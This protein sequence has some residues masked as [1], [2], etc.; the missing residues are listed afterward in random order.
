MTTFRSC[1]LWCDVC[2]AEFRAPSGMVYVTDAR[3]VAAQQGW[4][5]GTQD[6]RASPTSGVVFQRESD[7]CPA[8]AGK[9]V[10]A[11]IQVPGKAHQRDAFVLLPHPMAKYAAAVIEACMAQNMIDNEVLATQVLVALRAPTSHWNPPIPST[12]PEGE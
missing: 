12:V 10:A 4:T 7:I 8:C 9:T 1:G 3:R 2:G 6:G 11:G 5:R